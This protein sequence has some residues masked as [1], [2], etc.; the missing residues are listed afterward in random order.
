MDTSQYEFRKV[1]SHIEV[2]SQNRFI[3]S[4][5]NYREALHLL[6]EELEE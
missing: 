5:D 6:Q 3:L 1:D 4:A 2:Y